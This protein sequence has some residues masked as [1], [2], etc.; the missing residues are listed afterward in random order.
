MSHPSHVKD[1]PPE[2]FACLYYSRS[3]L[4]DSDPMLNNIEEIC[5]QLW[6]ERRIMRTPEYVLI[7]GKR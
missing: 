6:A 3:L 5:E 1:Y 2:C 4:K 7:R